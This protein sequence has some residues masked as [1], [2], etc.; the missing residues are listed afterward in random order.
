MQTRCDHMI[1]A[2]ERRSTQMKWIVFAA[3][4]D[5]NVCVS[6]QCECMRLLAGVVC[7]TLF[8]PSCNYEMNV[9]VLSRTDYCHCYC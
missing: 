9:N 7:A 4:N 1:C 5:R 6:V 3:R 2:A 8:A